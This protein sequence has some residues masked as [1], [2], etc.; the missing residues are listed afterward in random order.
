MSDTYRKRK[1][2][3][4]DLVMNMTMHWKLHPCGFLKESRTPN[5]LVATDFSVRRGKWQNALLRR[6]LLQV[7][8]KP[9]VIASI[10]SWA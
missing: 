1:C 4:T 2:E 6:L 7:S 5:D 10:D 8:G 3:Y 9:R